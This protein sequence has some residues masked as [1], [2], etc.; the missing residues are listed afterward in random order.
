M[1]WLLLVLAVAVAAP[2]LAEALRRPADRRVAP[3]SFAGTTGGPTHYRWWG[4]REGPVAV[5][6]HGLTTPSR[7]FDPLVTDLVARGYRVLT[8]DLPGRGFT[9]PQAGAQDLR[10]FSDQL[11]ELL[12]ELG[13]DEV[14]L[15]VGYSMGGAIATSFTAVR[16]DQVERL[17]L[18]APVGFVTDPGPMAEVIRRLPALGDWLMLGLGPAVLGRA[19]LGPPDLEAVQRAELR[20]RGYFAA[21]VS[22]LRHAMAASLGA[23]HKEIAALGVPLLAVWGEEDRV[24]PVSNMGRLAQVNRKAHQVMVAG[25]DHRLPFTHSADVAGA[26]REFLGDTA[27]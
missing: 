13:V 20:K 1:I 5:C 11:A 25:A 8:Y 2:F 21:V 18:L 15:L 10:F 6:V 7:I 4:P 19:I 16:A 17:V 22:S 9:P 12:D 14:D 3:G 27:W 26:I 24:I 23:E